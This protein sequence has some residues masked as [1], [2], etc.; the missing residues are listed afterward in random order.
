LTTRRVGITNK[1]NEVAKKVEQ[2]LSGGAF[3][4]AGKNVIPEYFPIKHGVHVNK[5]TY[6]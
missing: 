3:L 1:V 2:Q 5:E 6:E 4:K